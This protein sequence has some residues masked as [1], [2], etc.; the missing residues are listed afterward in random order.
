MFAFRLIARILPKLSVAKVDCDSICHDQAVVSDILVSPHLGYTNV[1]TL[2]TIFDHTFLTSIVSSPRPY[3]FISP[4]IVHLSDVGPASGSLSRC[5]LVTGS[6]RR[7]CPWVLLGSFPWVTTESL[8]G[9]MTYNCLY[10][11]SLFESH[12]SLIIYNDLS[13]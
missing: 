1:S 10:F 13:N 3:V 4:G 2:A 8:L 12:H 5:I 6:L 9:N 11:R 7:M